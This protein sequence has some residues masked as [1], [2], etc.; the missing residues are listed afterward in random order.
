LEWNKNGVT[1]DID[2]TNGSNIEHLLGLISKIKN[3]IDLKN[4][5]TKITIWDDGTYRINIYKPAPETSPII[6]CDS[7]YKITHKWSDNKI[8]K[9]LFDGEL[10]K[11]WKKDEEKIEVYDINNNVDYIKKFNNRKSLWLKAAKYQK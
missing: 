9:F 10:L 11:N 6:E 1:R 8:S 5:L 3:I 7:W 4:I 2:N